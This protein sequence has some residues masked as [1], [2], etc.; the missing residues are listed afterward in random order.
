VLRRPRVPVTAHGV[1][2]ERGRLKTGSIPSPSG[3]QRAQSHDSSNKVRIETQFENNM[4]RNPNK[5]QGF[6]FGVGGMRIT[7]YALPLERNPGSCQKAGS[8]AIN[9]KPGSVW[10]RPSFDCALEANDCASLV[11]LFADTKRRS[12]EPALPHYNCRTEAGPGSQRSWIRA[13]R[14]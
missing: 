11:R 3:P 1:G 14:R 5:K 10:V 6:S 4:R 12:I 8:I 7:A 2:P 13:A 9:R